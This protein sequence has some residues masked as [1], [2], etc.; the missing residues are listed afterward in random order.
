MF[1]SLEIDFYVTRFDLPKC[2]LGCE[3]CA[4]R[5]HEFIPSCEGRALE[6]LAQPKKEVHAPCQYAYATR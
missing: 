6:T 4:S 1:F 5:A 3:Q 2:F